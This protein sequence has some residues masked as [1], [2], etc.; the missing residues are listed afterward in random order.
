MNEQASSSVGDFRVT[1]TL[2]TAETFDEDQARRLEDALRAIDGV[3]VVA[4][5]GSRRRLRV[6]YDTSRVGFGTLSRALTEAGQPPPSSTLVRL[7]AVWF[8]YLDT[9]AR[10]NAH[11]GGGACCSNPSNI[12]ASRKH[13]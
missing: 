12:Y 6:A 13:K 4:P 9:N 3:H 2:R 7:R 11:A 1:R 5:E 8:D 10:A